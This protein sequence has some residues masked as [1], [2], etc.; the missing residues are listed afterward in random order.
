MMLEKHVNEVQKRLFRGI[1]RE[2]HQEASIQMKWQNSSRN[3]SSNLY[4]ITCKRPC[5]CIL[6]YQV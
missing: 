1:N 3:N 2:I 6:L 5:N 4:K